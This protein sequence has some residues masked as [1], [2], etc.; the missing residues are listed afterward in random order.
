MCLGSRDG[1]IERLDF[2]KT[3]VYEILVFF[4]SD[5][6]FWQ[7]FPL[8]HN[9]TNLVIPILLKSDS[10]FFFFFFKNIRVFH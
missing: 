5:F 8:I 6:T 7:A 1:T 4:F 9:I 2:I 10:F 3:N